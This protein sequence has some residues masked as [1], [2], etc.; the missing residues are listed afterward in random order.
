VFTEPL[1]SNGHIRHN[2]I[3]VVSITVNVLGEMTP[4]ILSDLYQHFGVHTKIRE[5]RSTF[6]KLKWIDTHIQIEYRPY[7]KKVDY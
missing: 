1:S 2:I 6:Q 7:G 5:N 4:Y 3:T